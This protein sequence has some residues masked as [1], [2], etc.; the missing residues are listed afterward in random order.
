MAER[1]GLSVAAIRDLEQGRSRRP[2]PGSVD[3]LARALGLDPRQS[4]ALAAARD[5]ADAAAVGAPAG[6]GSG[7]WLAVLGPLAA[8][9][10]GLAAGLGPPGQAA[11]AGLLAVQPGELVRRETVIDVLWGSK[12]P[13]TAAELVQAH[14]SRLRRVLDPGGRAGLVEQGAAGYRLHAGPSE[15]DAAAFAELAGRAGAVAASGDAAAACGLYAQALGLW[16]G[17]PA[18]DAR[19]LRGHPAVTG[20]ARRRVEVVLGY[21]D[22]ACRVGWY[23]R[24]L[25]LLEVLARELPLEE[26]VHARLIMALAGA[27]QQAAAI[28]IFEALRRRLDEDLGVRPGPELTAA[29]QRVLRQDILPPAD[30]TAVITDSLGTDAGQVSALGMVCTLPPDTA[31]FTGRKA[32]LDRITAGVTRA[33]AAGGVVAICPIGGMPGV[34]KT[35]LAV[36][37]AHLLADRFPDR[38]LFVSLHAHT[39]GQDPVTPETALV[40]LLAA[41]GVD[42]RYLPDDLEGRAALWRD[43]MA[44]QKALLVLDNA[45]SSAQVIPLLPGSA[46]C[47][48]LVTSR[49]YLGDLPGAAA[50]VQLPVLPALEAREMF[51]RL[52][53][54]AAADPD[55]AVAE[56]AG[57]AG[58]LPLAISL[59]ARV[60]ARHPSW[61]LADLAAE[62]RAGMLTLS[63][64]HDSVA[65]AFE[66]SYRYLAPD[67]QQFLR[68][69]GVHPGT[70]TDAYAAAA[71]AGIS[72]REAAGHLDALHGEGLL[73]ETGHR[74]YGMHDLIRSYARDLA[75]TDQAS[76]RQQAQ[77]RLLDYYQHTAALADKLLA[78]QARTRPAPAPQAI[79]AAVPDLTG[80]TQALAWARA[81]RATLLACLDQAT[82]AGQHARVI[83]LTAATASLLR[84]DG[85]WTSAITRHAAAI[86]AAR[87]LGDRLTQANTLNDLGDV[88]LLTGDHR[89]AA[90][91]QEEA[92]D[93]YRDISHRGGQANALTDLGSV[94]RVTG[95]Y[96]GAAEALE[97]ALDI[98]RDIG[99]RLGQAS[100]L[101]YLGDVRQLTGDYSGAAEAQEEALDIYRDISHQGGQ[102]N[103]LTS[104][105][106][107]RQVTGDYRGAAEALEEALDISRDISHRL[108][109][110]NALNSLGNVRQ[111]TGDYRG[112]AKAQEEALDIYRDIGGRGG[113]ANALISL[114]IVRRVTGDYR[115]AAKALEEALDISRDI[116][117]RHGEAEILN[118]TA[119]LYRVHGDPTRAAEYHRQALTLSREIA[120]PRDEACALAGLGRCALALGGTSDA[121]ENLRQARDLFQR[122]G[123]AEAA[124]VAA[125][126]DTLA[127][128]R[129]GSPELEQG[130]SQ[131]Y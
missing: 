58:F 2:R 75:A 114:G 44:G 105:G 104:L 93:I 112:A 92:L 40:G 107:V 103:A 65:A 126:L 41:V 38:Q 76:S 46:G 39:P 62:T 73:T 4:A 70:S 108:G 32:E 35:A 17:E 59:L 60:Y 18:E 53:P 29:Y 128:P 55:Q 9:R 56:L 86:Q 89:G 33:A 85:P 120:S 28:E 91:A 24:V 13:V 64:E 109:Q 15:L 25:P 52:A 121:A 84:L 99:N 3:A 61:T 71:L 80:R 43:R 51:V 97:K 19:V 6:H 36:H 88:R 117:Y 57:L 10:D 127:G 30:G 63:A 66:L 122:I 129:Q 22:A 31:A 68:R 94:R 100:S 78:R 90:E 37:A 5:A 72:L 87:H 12:P 115:G 1:S 67:Q 101:T 82:A 11:V 106:I 69:L 45:A 130:T 27:G 131:P 123:A 23:Q 48:V 81:E 7:L 20:L 47:L 124:G 21:A 95:D 26:R 119:A 102:A 16:R 34:G 77:D 125:E 98:S 110:A 118:E 8:W 83:A 74:R 42:A 96:S 116:S 113:Q 50:P 49:R 14:V 79:P 111:V 54:R